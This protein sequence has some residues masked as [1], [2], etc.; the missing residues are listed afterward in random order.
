MGIQPEDQNAAAVSF[1]QLSAVNRWARIAQVI[2]KLL[3]DV[4]LR[5]N[6]ESCLC[7]Y[8][9]RMLNIM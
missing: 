2:T 4:L 8:T 6:V 9:K 7:K 3:R 5:T 1:K